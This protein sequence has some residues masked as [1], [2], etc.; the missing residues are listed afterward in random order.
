MYVGAQGVYRVVSDHAILLSLLC[1]L[2]C[3][4]MYGIGCCYA[5]CCLL[6]RVALFASCVCVLLFVVVHIT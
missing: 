3:V 2:L 6:S 5:C 4:A 1:T